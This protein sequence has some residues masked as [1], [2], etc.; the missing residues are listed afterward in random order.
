MH[1][2]K[3]KKVMF[4][5]LEKSLPE[6]QMKKIE[7][8]LKTCS[9]CKEAYAKTEN[10]INV[11]RSSE[12]KAVPKDLHKNIMREIENLDTANDIRNQEIKHSFRNFARGTGIVIATL[13]IFLLVITVFDK[14]GGVNLPEINFSGMQ[15][16]LTKMISPSTAQN[17]KKNEELRTYD[18]AESE[19]MGISGVT[20]DAPMNIKK[21]ADK[22]IK[23]GS[24]SI[25]VVDMDQTMTEI[26]TLIQKYNAYVE[27]RNIYVY[28]NTAQGRDLKNANMTIRVERDKFMD[29]SAEIYKLGRVTSTNETITNVTKSYVDIENRIDL[30][31]TQ[32]ESLKEVLKKA[33]KMED[34]LLIME[35]INSTTNELEYYKSQKVN[36]N[37]QVEY[38]YL[39]LNIAEVLDYKEIRKQDGTFIEK[40]KQ[41]LVMA[42][43]NLVLNVEEFVLW[44]LANIFNITITLVILFVLFIVIKLIFKRR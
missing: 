5:Y 37:D 13:F 36:L 26:E 41:S 35:N 1:C 22:E 28:S 38:S 15:Q 3:M 42:T 6:K 18:M 23:Q 39:N 20:S 11:L 29:L 33:T 2:G 14:T 7:D 16:N 34:I 27:S 24:S 43:N 32:L 8:H 25:E 30:L 31:E 9:K 44:I 40:A 4:M 19:E 21:T 10:M 12:P 17:A